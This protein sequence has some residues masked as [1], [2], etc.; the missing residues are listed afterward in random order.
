MDERKKLNMYMDQERWA[1]ASALAA[2][3]FPDGRNAVGGSVTDLVAHLIYAAYNDPAAFGL[4][5]PGE[6]LE[7]RPS[8]SQELA[9]E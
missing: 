3:N 2:A 6:T 1:Q 4:V 7:D 5:G 8:L 9:R